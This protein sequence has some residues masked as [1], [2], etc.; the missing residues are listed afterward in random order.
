MFDFANAKTASANAYAFKLR[1][2][3]V[4]ASL[5]LRLL[6]FACQQTI[7]AKPLVCSLTL[8][9]RFCRGGIDN[10]RYMRF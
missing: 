4:H 3:F 7:G 10:T 6:M 2:A 1:C 9:R 5:T 8:A